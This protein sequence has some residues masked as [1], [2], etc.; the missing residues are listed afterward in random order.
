MSG[1][2]STVSTPKTMSSRLLT[3][4]FMQRAAAAS[5]ASPTASP[6]GPPAKRQKK[7]DV[8]ADFDVISLTDQKAIQAAVAEEEAKR[9]LALDRQAA[10]LGDTRWVLSFADEKSLAPSHTT[11]R[12]VQTGFSDLDR[13]PVYKPKVVEEETAWEDRPAKVGRRS[14]GKFNK[15][16]EVKRKSDSESDSDDS[17][18][19]SASEVDDRQDEDNSNDPMDN[20][21]MT[22]QQKAERKARAEKKAAEKARLQKLAEKRKKKDVN[23]NKANQSAFLDRLPKNIT[24]LSGSGNGKSNFAQDMICYNCNRPGHKASACPNKSKNR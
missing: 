4:K 7:G 10:E 20:L 23:L 2:A 22:E 13:S 5:A 19:E 12:V 24:S 9:Q 11:L 18:D 6:E 15:V 17:D 8:S 14:F 21:I 1:R 3:M 16:L